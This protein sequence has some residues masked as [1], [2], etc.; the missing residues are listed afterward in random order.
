M[1]Q[2]DK[3]KSSDFI[4]KDCVSSEKFANLAVKDIDT[5]S[6]TVTGFFNT[7]NF[8][9]YDGDILVMGC[10]KKS[11]KERGVDSQAIAKIK[12]CLNHDLTTLCGKLTTLEEREIDGISGIYF[13][14]KMAN[15]TLGIDTLKNY[16]DGIYDNHSIG[17]QY[18][19]EKMMLIEREGHGNSKQWDNTVAMLI[20]PEAAENRT[21]MWVIKE[22][23]M[24]EGSTVA[25]GA[26]SLTPF[27]GMAK[28]MN[29]DSVILSM[30]DRIEKMERTM[31]S[32]TQ[33]DEMMEAIQLQS[34]QLKTMLNDLS[35]FIVMEP[36]QIKATLKKKKEEEAKVV[37]VSTLD[38]E[39]MAK[40]FKLID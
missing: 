28:N 6:R 17:F 40:A 4:R 18:V 9:D 29:K 14:S 35:E 23:K 20:N 26:N 37:P 7:Y 12:H 5:Q 15:T 22:I 39:R 36:E 24:W 27:L 2:K 32:G 38:L 31:S 8:L 3:R 30:I 11:I 1:S 19:P 10:A 16:L 21:T 34:L 25:F 33:S 13:E